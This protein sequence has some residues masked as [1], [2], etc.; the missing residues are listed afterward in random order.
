MDKNVVN[1]LI[2]R[3]MKDNPDS[4]PGKF[5][6]CGILNPG[7]LNPNTAQEESQIP[8]TIEN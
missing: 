7:I 6:A 4:E 3:S 1:L 2:S 5:F 8:L